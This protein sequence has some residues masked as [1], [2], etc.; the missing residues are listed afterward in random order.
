MSRRR[1]LV[2]ITLG[3]PVMAALLVGSVTLPIRLWGTAL[4]DTEY[5]V[6]SAVFGALS[7]VALG[8]ILSARRRVVAE[9]EW[10][11]SALVA[12]ASPALMVLGALAGG[13][14]AHFIAESASSNHRDV[15]AMECRAY[16]G[17]DRPLDACLPVM[18][19][20]D[21]EV[22]GTDGLRTDRL[23]RLPV[24]WPAGLPMPEDPRAR[25]RHLCAWRTLGDPP[26]R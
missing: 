3:T 5:W 14:C 17:D 21:A 19:A 15:M 22:R 12:R 20:C 4:L 18:D 9:D 25:A 13:V 7:L 23:G 11:I 6:G 8:I 24:A 10:G 1:A 2:I 26:A 16:L